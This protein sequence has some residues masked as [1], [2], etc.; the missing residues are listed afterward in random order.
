MVCIEKYLTLFSANGILLT[1]LIMS[2][3][4]EPP[5]ADAGADRVLQLPDQDSVTLT[6][7]RSSDDK[8]I[9]RYQA[10]ATS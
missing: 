5:V 6:G 3:P 1:S 2:F 8:G 7:E 10:S 9:T 4:D